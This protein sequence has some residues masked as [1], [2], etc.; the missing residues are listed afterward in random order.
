MNLLLLAFVGGV[1][2]ATRLVDLPGELT[3]WWLASLTALVALVAVRFTGSRWLACA[4]CGFFYTLNWGSAVIADRLPFGL[5]GQ[6]LVLTGTVRSL[7]ETRGGVIR[8]QFEKEPIDHWP[9]RSMISLSWYLLAEELPPDLRPGQ[10]WEMTV[11]LNR[12]RGSVNPG[13]FDYEGWMLAREIGATG[14]VRAQPAPRLLDVSDFRAL[15]HQLRFW[16]RGR[17]L[18]VLADSHLRGLVLALTIGE[19]GAI[20]TAYWNT[21]SRT[22]TNHLLIISGLHVGLVAGLG[23]TLF[24]F[25][26]GSRTYAALLSLLFAFLYGA[27]A[28]FGLPVQRSLVMTAC[29]LAG[30]ALHRFL[31]V[32]RLYCLAL[33]AVV[34]MNPF[35][36]LGAGFWLSFGAVAVLLYAF[37]GRVGPAGGLRIGDWFMSQ[38]VVFVGTAP[39]LVATVFQVS[40][41]AP[42]ANLLAIPLVGFLLVPLLLVAL[43]LLLFAA[44]VGEM[45]LQLTVLI[46]EQVWV[47]LEALAALDW[48]LYASAVPTGATLLA[49]A[50]A[51]VGLAPRGLLPRWLGVCFVLPMVCIVPPSPGPGEVWIDVLDVGQGL[52]VVVQTRGHRLLY[53]TGPAYGERFDTGE[54]VISPW[55]RR[56]GAARYLDVMVVSHG[57]MDHAGGASAIHRN[58]TID[59]V[60]GLAAGSPVSTDCA[61]AS[62]WQ[63]GTTRFEVL[64]LTQ[65]GRSDNDESCVLL[66][67]SGDFNLLLP[68][69]IEQAGERALIDVELPAIDLL[70]VPHHGSRSS[71]TPAFINHTRPGVAIYSTGYANR[72]GHPDEVVERRYR[73][74][75]IPTLNT[76]TQGAIQVRYAPGEGVTVRTGR[77][78]AR[79]FWYD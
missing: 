35:A 11:R 20:G 65:A 64:P 27:I 34:L 46:L 38:W 40:F 51:L 3:L 2:A 78:T 30:T 47:M 63:V 1:V 22:G 55:L 5:A 21:L 24:R 17:I 31:P 57:D 18:Q 10:R 75:G 39:L 25:L 52:A 42:V 43:C 73:R 56:T 54:Q 23:Y 60:F 77:Q 76:A 74:R 79:R 32:S 69:D 61:L 45:L 14:Y 44:P 7:P 41:I 16:L 68:G 26:L 67:S 8:F 9:G 37:A 62:Q 6:D 53:D 13:L 70:L 71:S 36:V 19:S 49:V 4:W 33:V 12:P 72:F 50:G 58:F 59:R 28:G 66:I 15:H 48:V 29:A